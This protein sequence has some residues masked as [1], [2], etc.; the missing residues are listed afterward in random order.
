MNKNIVIGIVII[1]AIGAIAFGYNSISDVSKSSATDDENL[2]TNS[3]PDESV[4][5]PEGKKFTVTLSDGVGMA[6]D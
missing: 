1:V 3:N 2:E 5:A 4:P 6:D